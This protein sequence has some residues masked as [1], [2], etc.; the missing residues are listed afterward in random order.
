[1]V[2]SNDEMPPFPGG[3]EQVLGGLLG[4]D[5][6]VIGITPVGV[7]T[8]SVGSFGSLFSQPQRSRFVLYAHED[9]YVGIC[10]VRDDFIVSDGPEQERAIKIKIT[11]PVLDDFRNNVLPVI[12][13]LMRPQSEAW[14]AEEINKGRFALDEAEQLLGDRIVQE[15]SLV[16]V[17]PFDDS[18]IIDALRDFTRQH[19]PRED[20]PAGF[21]GDTQY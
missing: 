8:V 11:R 17:P 2:N 15:S 6:T 12:E 16:E 10:A 14:S 9:A 5:V 20:R 3:L 7:G 21:F 1:M 19:V 4:G 13:R 18:P